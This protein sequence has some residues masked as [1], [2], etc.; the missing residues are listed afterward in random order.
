MSLSPA[1]FLLRWNLDVILIHYLLMLK[2]IVYVLNIIL[3]YEYL[4]GMQPSNQDSAS[5]F[6][7]TWSYH[8]CLLTCHTICDSSWQFV[9]FILEMTYF[10]V[11][12]SVIYLVC[13]V[14]QNWTNA[15]YSLIT[16]C[17]S[18][19]GYGS[20]IP[21]APHAQSHPLTKDLGEKVGKLVDQYL[22]AMEKVIE[23]QVWFSIGCWKHL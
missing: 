16:G 20:I 2:G 17:C 21:D 11:N 19:A 7:Q 1:K 8:I 18:G 9:I 22:D 13:A 10:S 15:L 5:F 23:Y 14:D 12:S 3:S 6:M 4:C